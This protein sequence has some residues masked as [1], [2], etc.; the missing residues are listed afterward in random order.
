MSGVLLERLRGYPVMDSL[1]ALP[2]VCGK[3]WMHWEVRPSYV[4][5]ESTSLH[6]SK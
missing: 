1:K 3:H 4:Y 2:K 6:N 5:Y